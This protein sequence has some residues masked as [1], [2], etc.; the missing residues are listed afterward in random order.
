MGK[1]FAI[2]ELDKQSAKKVARKLKNVN[3]KMEDKELLRLL[4]LSSLPIR[5]AAKQ[6][7]KQVVK[8]NN[9][10]KFTRKGTKYTI[11]PGT[12]EKSI[13]SMPLK[14]A[15]VP[16]V[17]VGYSARGKYDGWFAQFVDAG[18]INRKSKKGDRGSIQ[19]R[20]IMSAGE[21]KIPEAQSRLVKLV[22]KL[23]KKLDK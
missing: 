3:L 17:D 20:N 10:F 22:N 12:I 9:G 1:P 21:S 19:P 16:V 6:R 15:K 14:K 2:I 4:R 18:T 8:A 7:A 13:K 5:K 11:L 23:L